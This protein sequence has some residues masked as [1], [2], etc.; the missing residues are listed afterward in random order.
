MLPTTSA[1]T[2]RTTV[3]LPA[4][5]RT[6]LSTGLAVLALVAALLA[7][8]AQRAHA[9]TVDTDAWYV[10][11]ARHS[12][13]V[14]DVRG[15]STADGAPV[16]QWSRNDGA[17]QQW[18]FV[19]VGNGYY[20]IRARHSGK[21]LEV[22]NALDGA[23]LVQRTASTSTRQHFRLVDS[24]DGSVRLVNR[25]SGKVVDVWERS[26]ADGAALAQYRDLDGTNQRF[27][28]VRLGSTTTPPAQPS[29]PAGWAGQNGGTTGGG[30]ATP[31]RVTSA[32]A[33]SAALGSST[34]AVVRVSGTITCSG[35]LRVRS[36]KTV[37]GEPGATIAGC[38]LTISGDR[39]VIV[40]N[41]SFRD[42]SD[43][44]V[45]V[46]SGATNVWIDHNSFRNGYDGA[47]DVKRGADF[48]TVSWNR[49]SAHGKSMLL[50]H[51]DSNRSQDAGHLRVT[52]HHNWFDGSRTRHP[53]VRF[54]QGVHVYNNYYAGNEYGVASTMDAAVLVEGNHF[55]DVSEPTLVGYADSAP[56]ALVQ[57][58]NLFTRSGAPQS[59]GTVPALPYTY[60]L[61][62]VNDVKSLVTAGAGA[63]R[64]SL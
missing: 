56:G 55:E 52:Y 27:A 43:D 57:R 28:L 8:P 34:P 26:T 63:G 14:A 64:I 61:D 54:A 11:Q 9:A 2:S 22:P 53:R 5:T 37:L 19:P 41:L 33:L 48:V 32:S 13:K 15:A 31:T 47:V 6:L 58:G 49:V 44:A 59:A 7:V 23:Q 39:N 46:E 40:R 20:A 4:A 50:G 24:A 25:H 12:G 36:N 60:V 62:P 35:M 3:A 10:L 51:S 38:G 30:A 1:G 42:W 45:N 16:V 29:G 21:V 18:R 17:H